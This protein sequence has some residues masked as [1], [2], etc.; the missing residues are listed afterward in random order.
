[1]FKHLLP[2]GTSVGGRVRTISATSIDGSEVS[3]VDQGFDGCY[4]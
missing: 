4:T 3:F 2:N 1:M